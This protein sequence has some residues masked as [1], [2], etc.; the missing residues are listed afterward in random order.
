VWIY[1]GGFNTGNSQSPA[2]N[3][4]RL[5]NDSDVVVV[6]MNYRINIFGFPGAD[7]LKDK[8]PG[9]M[10]QRLAVEWCEVN[11]K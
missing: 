3:G 8:N 6:S 10:D 5:A 2:Y 11:S 1:G 7:F 9:L 4:A